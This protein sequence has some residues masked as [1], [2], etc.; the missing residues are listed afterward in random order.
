MQL[1]LTTSIILFNTYN[2]A[3]LVVFNKLK[4]NFN[5]INKFQILKWLKKGLWDNVI[6]Y[7][8]TERVLWNKEQALRFEEGRSDVTGK[9]SKSF[10]EWLSNQIASF[11]MYLCRLPCLYF[12]TDGHFWIQREKKINQRNT[13]NNVSILFFLLKKESKQSTKKRWIGRCKGNTR[14][15]KINK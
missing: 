1:L 15:K 11:T 9:K 3:C 4:R 13:K 6:F 2:Y 8:R 5:N 12:L 7:K 10:Q 14:G